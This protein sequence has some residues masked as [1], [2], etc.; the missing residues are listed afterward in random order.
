MSPNRPRRS[1]QQLRE[2][3]PLSLVDRPLVDDNHPV[4]RAGLNQRAANR[5]L[6]RPLTIAHSNHNRDRGHP[7]ERV[8]VW[9]S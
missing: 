6:D 5:V 3:T 8:H 7:G 4:C 1:T 2:D 9:F